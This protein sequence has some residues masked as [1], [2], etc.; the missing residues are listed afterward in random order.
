MTTSHESCVRNKRQRVESMSNYTLKFWLEYDEP[1]QKRL[2]HIFTNVPKEQA[3]PKFI[4]EKLCLFHQQRIESLDTTTF[5]KLI[6]L[7]I[8]EKSKLVYKFEI[9][10]SGEQKEE[11]FYLTIV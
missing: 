2:E 5:P 4:K 8:E 7:L 9:S 6:G 1:F 10:C 3:N 11:T